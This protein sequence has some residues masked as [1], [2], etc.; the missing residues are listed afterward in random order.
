[1]LRTTSNIVSW[2]PDPSH[3]DWTCVWN[4]VLLVEGGE[5]DTDDNTSDLDATWRVAAPL[6]KFYCR[7]LGLG[8]HTEPEAAACVEPEGSKHLFD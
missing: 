5:L 4:D 2:I 3:N 7:I 6:K 1:M 8:G